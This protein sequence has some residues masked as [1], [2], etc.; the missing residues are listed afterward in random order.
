MSTDPTTGADD[1]DSGLEPDERLFA[2]D[3]TEDPRLDSEALC[4]CGLLWSTSAAAGRVVDLLSAGDFTRPTHGELF[5]LVA[6]QLRQGRPHDPASI[7]AVITQQGTGAHRGGL[8]TTALADATAAGAIP[9]SA[10]HH[11][12]N[13]L[14]AGYRRSFHTAAVSMSQAAEQLLTDELFDHLVDIS[15]AQ[16]TATERLRQATAALDASRTP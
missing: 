16:R 5:T 4:L 8:L 11:A 10:G 1:G 14:T 15:R 12:V 9:E 7:A 13:I 6:D 3:L 2:E